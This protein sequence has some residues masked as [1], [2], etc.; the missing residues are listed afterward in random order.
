MMVTKKTKKKTQFGNIGILSFR[1][2]WGSNDT[3]KCIL[4][5]EQEKKG[6]KKG[7]KISSHYTLY[8]APSHITTPT[9]HHFIHC[10]YTNFLPSFCIAPPLLTSNLTPP[11]SYTTL[12]EYLLWFKVKD[13][14]NASTTYR[15]E[16]RKNRRIPILALFFDPS[17]AKP[18]KMRWDYPN[19]GISNFYFKIF[20]KNHPPLHFLFLSFVQARASPSC[21]WK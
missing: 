8:S 18:T 15:M 20:G 9:S 16:W 13:M 4:Y 17:A 14:T 11:P 2:L 10:M 21:L 19:R 7:K 12:L 1:W 6:R 5:W 3:P